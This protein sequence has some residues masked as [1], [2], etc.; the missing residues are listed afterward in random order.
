[1]AKQYKISAGRR[2][3]HGAIPD[4]GGVNFSIFGLH[5]TQAELLLY[6]RPDSPEPF[7]ILRLDP[8]ENKTFFSWHV[9][10]EGLPVGTCYTWRFDGPRDTRTTG[11]R[12]SPDKELL[13]PWARAVTDH[14]WNRQ[15]VIRGN[16]D[17]P[18]SYRAMVVD[19]DGY[20]WEGDEPLNQP[21]EDTIIY[22]VH[23]GGFTRHR[24]SKVANPGSFAGLIEKIP[25]LKSLGVTDIELL[26][27]MAFDEQDIPPGAAQRGLKNY[28]GYSP[29]SFFSPHPGYC[30]TPERGTHRR[31]FKDLVKALH[32][33][34]IGVILD[35]VF[36]HTAEGGADG[37][38]INFKGLGNAGF[39]HLDPLDRSRYHDYTGCGN[40]INANHPV[41]ADLLHDILVYWVT[42]FHVDGFRF[43]LASALCR[44]EDGNPLRNAPVLWGIELSDTL[45]QSRIIAEAWDAVG[46]YQVGGFPG[47]RWREW[48]GRYRD[49]IRRFV[50]GDRGLLGE[51]AT[52]VSG[53]SD[54]YAYAGR[55]PTNSIN[56][57]T[58][59]DG[60]TLHDLLSYNGKHNEANGEQN[61]DG[62]NENYSWNCGHEGETED[63]GI[64]ALRKRQAK[65]LLAILMVSQGVPMILAGDEVLQTQRGNNNGYCQDN[66]LSWFDWNRVQRHADMLQFV[67][68]LIGFRKRH[69]SLRRRRFLTGEFVT[70]RAIA[71]VTWHG[72]R[73]HAPQWDD[74]DSQFLAYTLAA[75]NDSQADLHI[76]FNMSDGACEAELPPIPDRIWHRALDTSLDSPHDLPEFKQQRALDQ[77]RYPVQSR[78]VVVLEGWSAGR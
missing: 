69:P 34:G 58:C 2:Y 52:R 46:L 68:R 1:M 37:P 43:D 30:V 40:T 75:V 67:Q 4:Q 62:T 36:N 3:P 42:E 53:S 31:E 17:R 14:F 72:T 13:D 33:A 48:N 20:D 47:F 65:N 11:F 26:P 35:V 25:Y 66:E 27:V 5:A 8:E 9:Y 77:P 50:R 32:R 16:T 41:V 15:A 54:L 51:V 22:E 23:V 60:F 63:A 6:E 18:C 71:D 76:I 55:L 59:H 24:S 10:V 78:S 39:Y 12:F 49:V 7:Q 38:T 61:R 21:L 29:H 74:P 28:W 70:G 19:D 64:L 57:I 45:S 73:L 56:F 44:G